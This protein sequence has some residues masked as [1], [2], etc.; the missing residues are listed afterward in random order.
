MQT[1]TRTSIVDCERRG[2]SGVRYRSEREEQVAGRLKVIMITPEKSGPIMIRGS[3]LWELVLYPV[4]VQAAVVRSRQRQGPSAER[5]SSASCRRR[6]SA[7][8]R[9]WVQD[10]AIY[11][12]YRP[13]PESS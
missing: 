11:S 3:R 13:S 5:D 6:A 1:L 8:Y 2:G 4:R 10:W 12:R 7:S 9:P